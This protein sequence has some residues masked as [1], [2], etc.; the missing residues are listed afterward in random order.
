MGNQQ[1]NI[2]GGGPGGDGNDD[3]SKK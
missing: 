3:K 1:S 2:G